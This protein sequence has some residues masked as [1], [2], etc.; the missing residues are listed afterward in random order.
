MT[1]KEYDLVV[2]FRGIYPESMEKPTGIDKIIWETCRSNRWIVG[3]PRVRTMSLYD[4]RTYSPSLYCL[5]VPQG[6]EAL[7]EFEQ[8]KQ[9]QERKAEYQAEQRARED[10]RL[11]LEEHRFSAT[12]RRD[13]W[14]FGLGL[15]VGWLLGSV[16]PTEVLAFVRSLI[17]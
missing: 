9:Q 8:E 17:H 10:S 5:G 3:E 1:Q 15:F 12:V 7:Q 4:D 13:W 14:K 2:Q 11:L 6:T 16:A